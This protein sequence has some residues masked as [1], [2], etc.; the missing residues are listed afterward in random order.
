MGILRF[1]HGASPLSL[2]RELGDEV[3]FLRERVSGEGSFSAP[4]HHP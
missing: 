1:R 2:W 3:Q 4:P